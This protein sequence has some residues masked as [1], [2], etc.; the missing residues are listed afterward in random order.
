M[1]YVFIFQNK[2]K[3]LNYD[4]LEINSCD[5]SLRITYVQRTIITSLFYVVNFKFNYSHYTFYND[6]LY[7]MFN[8]QFNCVF[9]SFCLRSKESGMIRVNKVLL[10]QNY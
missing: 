9:Y 5:I 8:K 7:I 2:K 10:H 6:S 3:L 4:V 1:Y